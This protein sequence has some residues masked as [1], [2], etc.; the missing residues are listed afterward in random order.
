MLAE[1][2]ILVFK[3]NTTDLYTRRL[4]FIII[5][6]IALITLGFWRGFRIDDYANVIILFAL[7]ILVCNEFVKWY[8]IDKENYLDTTYNHLEEL[9]SVF[10]AYLQN[11]YLRKAQQLFKDN[12]DTVAKEVA[13]MDLSSMYINAELINLIYDVHPILMKVNPKTFISFVKGANNILSL[14][15]DIDILLENTNNVPENIA[16]MLRIAMKLKQNTLNNLHSYIYVMPI[17]NVHRK[18]IKDTLSA[19]N[20]I[21]TRVLDD[22]YSKYVSTINGNARY[23]TLTKFVTYGPFPK[24]TPSDLFTNS[25]KLSHQFY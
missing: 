9:Q 22:I 20:I 17:D 8:K 2:L 3:Q 13:R 24:E 7:I 16:N 18:Y 14:K 1:E 25:S 5:V 12:A 6:I 10:D 23:N 4:R 15:R 19:Y 21:I 11:E